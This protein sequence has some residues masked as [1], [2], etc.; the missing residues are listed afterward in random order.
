MTISPLSP[1]MAPDLICTQCSKPM[2]RVITSQLK[3]KIDKIHYYCDSEKCKYGVTLS[4]THSQVTHTPY[5][6]PEPKKNEPPVLTR[7][8]G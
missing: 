6:E 7:P 1:I 4:S 2:R 5:A 3:T 8:A